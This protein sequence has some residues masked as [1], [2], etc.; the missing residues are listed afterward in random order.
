MQ[1][2]YGKAQHCLN[3][4]DLRRK[5]RLVLPGGVFGYLA[6]H[7]EDG[8]CGKRN[9]EVF[10]DWGLIPRMLVDV[11]NVDTSVTVLGQKISFPVV[12]APTA[13]SRLFHHEGELAVAR[14][15][16]DAGT[17][18]SLSTLSSVSIEEVGRIPG[19]K[20]FQL[21]M[22]RDKELVRDLIRRS[23]QAG[24]AALCITVDAAIA[25][26]REQDLRNGFVIPPR[27]SPGTV[28]ESLLH[29]L[30]CYHYLNSEKPTTANFV[31][32][33]AISNDKN[34]NLLQYVSEQLTPSV[35]WDDIEWLRNEFDG[36]LLIKGIL[37]EEDAQRARAIGVNG[38]VLSNHGGRQLDHAVS[39]MDTLAEVVDAVGDGVEIIVD[40]GIRRGTDVIKALALG[41]KA[42]MIGRPYL[43]GLAAF[44]QAGV[45]RAL[46][47]FRSEIA[48]DM[49]LAGCRTIA[50]IDSSLLKPY[51]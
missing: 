48:R 13:M 36:P 23:K 38:I 37:S 2:I 44:G 42:C 11:A 10:A 31:G 9:R 8:Y 14:A 41:A 16:A 39:P 20:W 28:L 26:N 22:Y 15:A 46:E 18:Y 45:A 29:P 21:Y 43:Y 17:V 7:A 6:N 50:D 1:V 4:E 25:G 34:E 30:W 35:S 12:C 47:I 49:Q 51:R 40:S 24:Y 27:P 33:K 19:L 32:D 5:A 3:I